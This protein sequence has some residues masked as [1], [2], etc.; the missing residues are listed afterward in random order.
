V[1]SSIRPAPQQT[2]LSSAYW[3][4]WIAST[5]SNL[6]DG[7][8]LVALPL[9]ASRLTSSPLSISLVGV[10]A[11]LPWLVLPLPI[12]AIIDRS[13]RRRLLLQADTFRTILVGLLAVV[14]ASGH[15]RIWMLWVVALGLGVAEVFFDNASQAILPAIVPAELLEK[16]NG[17]R[18]SAE[19]TAN[20]FVGTPLGSL[21][22]TL[23]LWL[24]FV[25]DSLS[26]MMAVL[27]VITV[28][29]SFRAPTSAGSGSSERATTLRD[30]VRNGLSWLWSHRLLRGLA[31]ALGLSNFG[32][33]MSQAVFVLFAKERLHISDGQFGL[34][35]SAMGL[36][37]IVGGL[38]GDRLVA[39]VGRLVALYGSVVVWII[40]LTAVGAVPV[41]WFVTVMAAIESLAATVWNVVTVSLRQQIVP[42]HLFGRVNSV[43]RWFGWGTIPLGALAGGEVAHLFGLRMP[44]FVGAG[45]VAVALVVLVCT[46]T[47]GRLLQAETEAAAERMRRDGMAADSRDDHP[48]DDDDGTSSRDDTPPHIERDPSWICLD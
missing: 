10:F 40:T 26:Y 28:R 18:Y 34:L 42:D 12:G 35:L 15:T 4:L 33:Q 43:Y 13:D 7:V 45:F 38:V 20:I 23:A 31:I 32:F 22:F 2:R 3:R 47:P 14:V 29:G 37:A 48:W 44:Y 39:A 9:M 30:D 41:A 6:G 17:R 21:F 46:V 16:A 36:G 11:G 25:V 5:V 24:P 8:F 27:L 19:V 1:T